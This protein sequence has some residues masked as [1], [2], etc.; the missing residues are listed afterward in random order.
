[1]QHWNVPALPFGTHQTEGEQL[2]MHIW[3]AYSLYRP[4]KAACAIASSTHIPCL[5]LAQGHRQPLQERPQP[6]PNSSSPQL[7]NPSPRTH[8]RQAR[9]PLTLKSPPKVNQLLRPF[10]CPLV[11]YHHQ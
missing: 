2:S 9:F 10:L 8:N 11:N 5:S 3:H 6:H 4:H 1:M 7:L